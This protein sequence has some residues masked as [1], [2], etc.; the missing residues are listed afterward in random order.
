MVLGVESAASAAWA[1]T[2]SDKTAAAAFQLV[3]SRSADL[4]DLTL[5]RIPDGGVVLPRLLPRDW[6][7]RAPR[8]AAPSEPRGPQTTPPGTKVGDEASGGSR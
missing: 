2:R 8:P 1:Q 4:A 7:A 6:P 3:A 5:D